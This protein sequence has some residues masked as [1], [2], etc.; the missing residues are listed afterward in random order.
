MH[1]I[2]FSFS[3]SLLGEPASKVKSL[4]RVLLAPVAVVAAAVAVVVAAAAPAAGRFV[5]D[6]RHRHSNSH[7]WTHPYQ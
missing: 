7:K 5:S 1:I 6:G 4:P 3:L 2:C